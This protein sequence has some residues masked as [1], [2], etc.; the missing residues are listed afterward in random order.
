MAN[1]LKVFQTVIQA[2]II[3]EVNGAPQPIAKD[4]RAV[5][6]Q[7][8]PTIQVIGASNGDIRG[9]QVETG[10]KADMPVILNDVSLAAF[11]FIPNYICLDAADGVTGVLTGVNVV[12]E[13]D[14]LAAAAS[15]GIT[16]T[17]NLTVV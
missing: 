12:T 13:I 2:N 9:S 17:A 14:V 5:A 10:G 16:A 1:G 7:L 3:Y 15:I 6:E 8:R 4:A 11:D